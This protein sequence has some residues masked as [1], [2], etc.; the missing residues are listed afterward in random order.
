[1]VV[2]EA[3]VPSSLVVYPWSMTGAKQLSSSFHPA[4]EDTSTLGRESLTRP[5]HLPRQRFL[6]SFE[7][8]ASSCVRSEVQNSGR[9]ST[10]NQWVGASVIHCSVTTVAICSEAWPFGRVLSDA[11][12]DA[13]IVRPPAVDHNFESS[14]TQ[15]RQAE[16]EYMNFG[17]HTRGVTR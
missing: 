3:P 13:Q 10:V 15:A 4:S 5:G 6:S 8:H 14:K 1:M 2:I 12:G 7:S 17:C 11:H 9:V 16:R